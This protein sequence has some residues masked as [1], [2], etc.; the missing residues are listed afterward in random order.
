MVLVFG[1]SSWFGL[2]MSWVLVPASVFIVK[3]LGAP[4]GVLLYSAALL[5]FL[6]YIFNSMATFEEYCVVRREEKAASAKAAELSAWMEWCT[7]VFSDQ[8]TK[9]E[10]A[11]H[12]AI[13]DRP[14]VRS[15]VLFAWL[16][17]RAMSLPEFST[18]SREK[19]CRQ[20]CIDRFI[21]LA[22]TSGLWG[23]LAS[24]GCWKL[25]SPTL[26]ER[27]HELNA[28]NAQNPEYMRLL[29]WFAHN[30]RPPGKLQSTAV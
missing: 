21:W 1:R 30:G 19:K 17:R 23:E 24:E 11:G 5:V 28:R 6:L 25:V 7:N 13:F 14:D 9:I 22:E 3:N 4:P 18:S 20:A 16:Y 8:E 26:K 15:H 29:E 10:I 12:F 2:L 27:L